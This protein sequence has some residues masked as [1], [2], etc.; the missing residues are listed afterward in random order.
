MSGW[1]PI[2]SLQV[3]WLGQGFA[4]ETA[5]VEVEN[6]VAERQPGEVQDVPRPR[7]LGFGKDDDGDED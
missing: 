2:I 1:R 6:D 7:R 4:F 3:A 5:P